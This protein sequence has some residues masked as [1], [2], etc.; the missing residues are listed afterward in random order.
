MSGIDQYPA[1][2]DLLNRDERVEAVA[3][4]WRIAKG[5]DV[6][7]MQAVESVLRETYGDAVVAD[8]LKK[9]SVDHRSLQAA[10]GQD[11][12]GESA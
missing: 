12:G 3:E 10:T 6:E 2:L 7:T 1:G 9:E 8:A 4:I 11:E 5:E